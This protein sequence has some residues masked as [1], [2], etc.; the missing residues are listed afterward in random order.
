VSDRARVVDHEVVYKGRVVELHRDRVRLSNGATVTMEVVRH[1]GSVVLLPMLDEAHIVLVRQY[2][3]AIDRW[4][5]ELPAGRIERGEDF[6]AAARRECLEETGFRPS[7]VALMAEF[8]PTPGFCD[9][10]MKF[11]RLT[12]LARLAAGTDDVHQDPDEQLDV[13]VVGL[14][15]ARGMVRAGDI[16]DLKTAVGLT[17][18]SRP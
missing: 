16:V 15:D 13:R 14:E 9:E 1:P 11:C 6:D 2:R 3:Y 4:I 10:I 18:V 8:Y 7:G 5:W 12:G 17:L